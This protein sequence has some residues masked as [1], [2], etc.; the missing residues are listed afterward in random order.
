MR[1]ALRLGFVLLV[2]A[3]DESQ[4]A[5]NQP[6]CLQGLWIPTENM[7]T[8]RVAHAATLLPSGKV[9]VTGGSIEPV[10]RG[11]ATAELYDPETGTWS[12]TGSMSTP[13]WGHT[14]TLL[15]TGKVLVAGGFSAGAT[16]TAELYDPDTGQWTTT[17]AMVD[18]RYDHTATLLP[19]GKVLVVGG[20]DRG[21]LASAELYDTA[22]G[23]WHAVAALP[24]ARIGHT[25]TLLRSG[26]VL[27]LG[28]LTTAASAELYD[29][30]TETWTLATP[31]LTGRE[32]HTATLLSSGAVLVAGGFG[33][34][35]PGFDTPVLTEA[36]LYDPASG[37]WRGT[38]S[39]LTPHAGHIA[40]L[41]PSGRVLVVDGSSSLG[42]PSVP[43]T[44]LFDPD[45][46][47][48][49]N[50]GCTEEARVSHTATLLLSGGVLVA[51]G[52]VSGINA[53]GTAGAEVYGIV[54]S[55]AQVNLAPGASQI[56]TA[57]GG[58]GFDYVWS[59]QQ[60][61]S[62]GTLTASGDY[63][64]GPVGGVTDVIQ[65]VDSFAN[66]ASAT[67]VVTQQAT[68]VSATSPQAKSI[69]CGTTGG[70]P[71]PWL[72]AVLVLLGWRSLRPSR[73]ARHTPAPERAAS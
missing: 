10:G 21:F 7:S 29:P 25:A 62:G 2:V 9:L 69:G 70:A 43:N 4:A 49:D 23:R 8:P 46:G 55:P 18:A 27:V 14:M 41:L 12:P 22:T 65:V 59:F 71:L 36:E 16:D 19:T 34:S 6:F 67:V 38:G 37:T 57:R 31:M 63:Q 54:V 33:E 20:V 53:I 72:G 24:A 52:D 44:E 58:S 39:L 28:G 35:R 56:F 26:Q 30:A 51:G 15:P 61:N 64:A 13:R 66:S 5:G 42:G 1:H 60:D 40:T 48:W 11:L 45:S 17:G 47:T 68:T 32:L 73:R 3:P 50:A